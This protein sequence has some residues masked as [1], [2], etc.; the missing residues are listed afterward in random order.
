MSPSSYRLILRLTLLA[1]ALAC[2]VFGALRLARPVPDAQLQLL[3]YTVALLARAEQAARQEQ[4][5]EDE[6]RI[7]ELYRPRDDRLNAELEWNEIKAQLQRGLSARHFAR[8]DELDFHDQR[9]ELRKAL[10]AQ[11]H[12][13]TSSLP[14]AASLTAAGLLMLLVLVMKPARDQSGPAADAAPAGA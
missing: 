14:T 9:A 7:E 4:R 1:V 5:L 11:R 10:V 3:D 8:L 2:G 13:M 12:R 6:G